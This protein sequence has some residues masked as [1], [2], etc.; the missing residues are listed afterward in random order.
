MA[1]SEKFS[2]SLSLS[3]HYNN[4]VAPVANSHSSVLGYY[5]HATFAIAAAII[6]YYMDIVTM[7][8]KHIIRYRFGHDHDHDHD[9]D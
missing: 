2:L 4:Q 6:S 1:G 5:Y 7:Q 3:V 8:L 9:Y